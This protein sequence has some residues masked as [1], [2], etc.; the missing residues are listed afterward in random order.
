MRRVLIPT[1]L[2]MFLIFSCSSNQKTHYTTTGTVE[3]YKVDMR[4]TTP[5]KLIHVNIPEGK[6][7][8][9]GHLLA[10][11]DTTNLALQRQQA[12]I[13]TQG[14]QP[15]LQ[16]LENQKAQLKTRLTYLQKQ[17]DRFKQ[18]V[19]SEGMPQSDFDQ[20]AMERNTAQ[21]Q[22][23]NIPH[24]R[25]SLINQREQIKAQID[26]LNY[27]ISQAVIQSPSSGVILNRYVEPSE[28]V[29]PGHLLGTIGLTDSVWITMYIPETML[30]RVKLGD[31]ITVQPDGLAQTLSGRVE[32][33]SAEAEFT[34]KTVYT[35]D[36]RTSLS[37]GVRVSVPN[38]KGILKI[39]MPVTLSFPIADV[40]G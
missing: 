28:Q 23:E 29:Q 10:V 6:H 20:I 33:I 1:T 14:I 34:P 11:I 17:Y 22:L 15:Q 12:Q 21:Q 35:E 30:S 24:Q 8:K 16:S 36:T 18:L 32:W 26:L 7:I 25:E 19:K 3:A 38:P 4:A 9:S 39:G 27:Q 2:L 40:N 37:Y 13:K 31:Q 5:G